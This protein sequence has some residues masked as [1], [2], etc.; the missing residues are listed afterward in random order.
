[1]PGTIIDGATYF[2]L[3]KQLKNPNGGVQEK[4]ASTRN[5]S[6]T[7][8][9]SGNAISSQFQ[10]STGPTGY[11]RGIDNHFKGTGNGA[12]GDSKKHSKSSLKKLKK[13]LNVKNNEFKIIQNPDKTLHE[14]W[15]D[16]N[17]SDKLDSK[18]INLFNIPKPFRWLICGTPNSGK[19]TAIMN[20]LAHLN[21]SPKNVLLVHQK[22]FDPLFEYDKDKIELDKSDIVNEY[23][24]IKLTILKTIPREDYFQ[25]KRFEKCHTIL[26][27]DD[28]ALKSWATGMNN[29][30]VNK[31]FSYISTHYNVSI[32]SAFQDIYSQGIP[33]LYR[34][35]NIITIFKPR[36]KRMISTWSGNFGVDKDDLKLLIELCKTSHDSITLDGTND[37]PADIRLNFTQPIQFDDS[38]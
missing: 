34:F 29:T 8:N 35:S 27:M 23:K 21:P 7:T 9:K 37:S 17:H 24:D 20:I 3:L 2:Q 10:S 6:T 22:F 14:K 31:L 33:C 30:A 36:D 16:K 32:I 38:N 28:V 15:G 19:T 4:K 12:S 26:I 11:E 5:R 18:S 1:M 13:K 25:D